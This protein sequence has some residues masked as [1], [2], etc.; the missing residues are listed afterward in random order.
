MFIKEILLKNAEP[1]SFLFQ[2]NSFIVFFWS[3]FL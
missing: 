1:F 2:M 3:Y